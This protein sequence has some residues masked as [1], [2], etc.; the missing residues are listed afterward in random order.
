MRTNIE[1]ERQIDARGD[2]QR[3]NQDDVSDGR[4]VFTH[5]DS[6]EEARRHSE[7]PREGSVGRRIGRVATK[8]DGKNHVADG[9]GAR[10]RRRPLHKRAVLARGKDYVL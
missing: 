6:H 7:A 9:K 4:V 5:A 3:E 8:L 10:L 1:I 2:A